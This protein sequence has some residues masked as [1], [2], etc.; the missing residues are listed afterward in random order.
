M[1]HVTVPVRGSYVECKQR[2]CKQKFTQNRPEQ[3]RCTV[4]ERMI[5]LGL[6][7]EVDKDIL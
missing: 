1:Q 3:T 6:E 7:K 5:R 4:C 2:G